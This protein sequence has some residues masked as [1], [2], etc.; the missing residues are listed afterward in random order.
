MLILPW[1]KLLKFRKRRINSVMSKLAEE[2]EKSG[3][4]FNLRALCT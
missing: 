2:L 3:E 4:L 1:V